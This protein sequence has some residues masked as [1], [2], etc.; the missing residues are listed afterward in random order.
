MHF[1]FRLVTLALLIPCAAAAQSSTSDGVVALIRGDYATAVRILR[2]LAEEVAEPDPLAQF[3]MAHLYGAG[4]GGVDG[5]P[6]WACGLYLRAARASNPLAAQSLT[7]ATDVQ[8]DSPVLRS[9]CERASRGALGVPP[10]A[11]FT[12]GVDHSIRFDQSGF[13]V[14][15]HQTEK[16]TPPYWGG[17][18]AKWSGIDWVF[19]PLRHTQVDVS[20]PVSMRRHFLDFFVWEPQLTLDNAWGLTWYVHEVVGPDVLPVPG[21]GLVM[22]VAGTESPAPVRAADVGIIR[23]NPN[24]EAERV[25]LGANP[26]TTLIP[27]TGGR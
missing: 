2:P 6:I 10:P 5:N 12:L 24:G 16:T 14:R 25:T 9:L 19:M 13:T 18:N 22:S 21:N 7:I 23:V 3:F 1:R 8:G 15:Y 27:D 4:L 11:S 26:Q 20:R 17:A